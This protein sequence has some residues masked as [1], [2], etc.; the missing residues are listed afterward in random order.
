MCVNIRK[1]VFF[2]G[3]PNALRRSRWAKKRGWVGK[4][5]GGVGKDEGGRWA[6]LGKRWAKKYYH[7]ENPVARVRWATVPRTQPSSGQR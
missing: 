4:D 2:F 6:N 1:D 5:G 7:C 3:K